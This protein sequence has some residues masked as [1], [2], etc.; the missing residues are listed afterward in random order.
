MGMSI[1]KIAT[2]DQKIICVSVYFCLESFPAVSRFH[3]EPRKC[4]WGDENWDARERE[5]IPRVGP[6]SSRED[7]ILPR[8][9]LGSDHSQPSLAISWCIEINDKLSPY[10]SRDKTQTNNTWRRDTGGSLTCP[11]S[12]VTPRCSVLML[13]LV[14]VEPGVQAT[15]AAAAITQRFVR[16]GPGPLLA[17]PT[18][19]TGQT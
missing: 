12:C 4:S 19:Y 2:F 16:S 10:Q 13:S 11:L 5:E 7:W 1:T 9:D 3:D 17:A 15:L 8:D 18:H 14:A 6:G